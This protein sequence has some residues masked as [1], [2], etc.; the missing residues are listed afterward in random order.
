MKAF[1]SYSHRDE[2]KLERLHKHLAM[3]RRDGGISDW[4]DRKIKAGESIDRTISKE[5]E[6]CQIFLAL[7][8]PDFLASQY[9]YEREMSRAIERF[10]AGE[11]VIVP[12][13]L[14]PCDWRASTLGQF[15]ALPKDGKAV[16]EWANENTAFL[17]VVTE[18]RRLVTPEGSSPARSSGAAPPAEKLKTKYRVQRTFDEIDRANY[19]RS[20]YRTIKDY[21][22][23]NISEINSVEGIRALLEEIGPLAFTCTILNRMKHPTGDAS[24]TVRATPQRSGFGMG[25]LYYSFQPHAPENT[26]NGGFNV[27]SDDYELFL[28]RNSFGSDG[29]DRKWIP[30]EAAHRLW[31]ELLENAGISYDQGTQPS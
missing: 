24:L 19:R 18:L 27:E 17:D 20:A 4:V 6:S 23:R 14:E 30:D 8:S 26:A 31:E 11:L 3:L 29:R 21:F 13:I 2:A 12:V 9:C 28:K 10:E 1:I 16:S 22:E 25:D 5:L 7:V 15:K